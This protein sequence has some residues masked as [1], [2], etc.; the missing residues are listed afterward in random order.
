VS[1]KKKGSGHLGHSHHCRLLLGQAVEHVVHQQQDQAGTNGGAPVADREQVRAPVS[2]QLQA[3][4][5]DEPDQEV[6]EQSANACREEDEEDG[7]KADDD[8]RKPHDEGAADGLPEVA[9]HLHSRHDEREDELE[10]G[11]DDDKAEEEANHFE[12]NQ[13]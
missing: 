12:S 4:G 9:V 3:A 1:K 6:D 8:A 10:D 2:S 13:K 7:Q 11:G 5:V